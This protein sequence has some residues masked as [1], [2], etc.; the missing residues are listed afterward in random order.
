M[1][2]ESYEPVNDQAL[3]LMQGC[4]SKP[5]GDGYVS[6]NP[7]FEPGGLPTS[8]YHIYYVSREHGTATF[9]IELNNNAIWQSDQLPP[10]VT[11]AIVQEIGEIIERNDA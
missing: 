11:P 3:E 10:F 8:R 5:I 2:D 1:N 6:I 4:F 9:Y 7:E